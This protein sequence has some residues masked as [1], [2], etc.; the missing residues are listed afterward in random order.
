MRA[1]QLRTLRLRVPAWKFQTARTAFKVTNPGNS[2][3]RGQRVICFVAS[4]FIW[5]AG[6]SLS[7]FRDRVDTVVG[8][9]DPKAISHVSTHHNGKGLHYLSKGKIGKAET[10]FLKA[11]NSDPR[12]AAAH[13]NIGNM[14]LSRHELYQAA[15]EF[16]RAS[17]LAPSAIEPLINL[18]LV[19]EEGDQ[20]DEAAEYYRQAIN[21]QPNNA[22][23]VGN[24]VR[25]LVKQDAD[26]VEIHGFLKQLVFIDTRPDWLEWAQELVATRYSLEG[27]PRSLSQNPLVDSSFQPPPLQQQALVMPESIQWLPESITPTDPNTAPSYWQNGSEP[28]D[29]LPAPLRINPQSPQLNPPHP[30]GGA[31]LPNSQSGYSSL[32][33]GPDT[34]P[35]SSFQVVSP[36]APYSIPSTSTSGGRP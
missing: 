24:L 9:D 26:S 1:L 22:I 16:Q 11:V 28:L 31:Y 14:M 30:P 18:G 5:P 20:L 34:I 33:H 25:I 21:L 12:S 2:K 3:E 36:V 17:E 23:A 4:L 8:L 32:S 35:S 27:N 13:N 19:H 10:H 29:N 7:G 6:C 15:W